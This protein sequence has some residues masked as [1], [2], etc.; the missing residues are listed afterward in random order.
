VLLDA[1]KSW[2]TSAFEA[3]SYVWSSKPLA[4]EGAST[5]WLAPACRAAELPDKPAQCHR[6]A[7]RRTCRHN[8]LNEEVFDALVL[9]AAG[10][11]E[12]AAVARGHEAVQTLKREMAA[13]RKARLALGFPP[14]EAERLAELHARN[15]M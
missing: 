13:G 3:D 1:S 12:P 2:V 5:L 15:F 14:H 6:T 11:L 8:G 10:A 7:L 4:A 9:L